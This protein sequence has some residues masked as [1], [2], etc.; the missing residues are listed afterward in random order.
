MKEQ[1]N[2][3][4][5]TGDKTEYIDTIDGENPSLDLWRIQI[6]DAVL[7]NGIVSL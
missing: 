2:D 6:F 3:I 5:P 4:Q 7:K 1:K